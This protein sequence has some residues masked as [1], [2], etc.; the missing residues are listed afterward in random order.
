[1][2]ETYT[3]HGPSGSPTD[4]PSRPKATP[5]LLH[6]SIA[7]NSRAAAPALTL[8]VRGRDPRAGT[9]GPA[10]RVEGCPQ[11]VA[12]FRRG[13]ALRMLALSGLP[14]PSTKERLLAADPSLRAHGS[15][16]VTQQHL[17]GAPTQPAQAQATEP[18]QAPW[19]AP[20][21]RG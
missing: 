4:G 21:H 12:D 3:A 6:C 20:A 7:V 2:P 5:V 11:R 13:R 18:G 14:E 9:V 16:S 15:G 19:F 1:V 17:T 10:R 8:P